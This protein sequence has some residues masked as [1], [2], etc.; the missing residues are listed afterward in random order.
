MPLKIPPPW[1]TLVVGLPPVALPLTVAGGVC[2]PYAVVVPYSNRY[3]VLSL[4]GDTVP[5]SVAVD[6]VTAVAALVEADG[7]ANAVMNDVAYKT[8]LDKQQMRGIIGSRRTGWL[9]ALAASAGRKLVRPRDV[10]GIV[11]K[12]FMDR[13][14]YDQDRVS[15]CCHHVLDTHGRLESFCEYNALVRPKD[16]WSKFPMLR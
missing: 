15:A 12:P 10:F 6:A 13:F 4:L 14:T 11:I 9:R 8:V 3:V 2:E 16:S 1:P 7:A 5:F